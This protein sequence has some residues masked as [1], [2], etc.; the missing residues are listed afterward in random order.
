MCGIAGFLKKNVSKHISDLKSMANVL[1]HRGPDGEGMWISSDDTIGMIHTRLSIIDLTPAGDQPMISPSKR[2]TM[3]FNGEVYNHQEIKCELEKISR[4]N[5]RGTSDTEV[6]LVAIDAW[7]LEKALSKVRGMLSIALWDDCKKNIYLASDRMGEKPLYYGWVGDSFVFGSELKSLKSISGL[8][9]EIDRSSLS[10]YMRYKSIPAPH[11]IYKDIYKITPG[12]IIKTNLESQK[13]SKSLYWSID[14][15]AKSGCENRFKGSSEQAVLKLED[16]LME[17]IDLQM[18]ADV[19]LGSFLSGGVDSSVVS[20]LMQSNSYEKINTFSIGFKDKRFNEAEYARA[21]SKSIGSSHHDMY[22]TSYD[23]MN[24]IPSLPSI[25][26][27]PFS[28]SS[29]IPTFLV[30]KIAKEKVSVV[31][32]GDG[33]DELFGGYNRYTLSSKLWGNIS[34]IPLPIRGLMSSG[35]KSISPK[36]WDRLLSFLARSKYNNFGEKFHKG[37]N[38]LNCNDMDELYVNLISQVGNP[39]SWVLNSNSNEC[40]D[41]STGKKKRFFDLSPIERMMANDLAGYLSADILTKVD[42]A[43]MAVSLEARTPF[44]DSKVVEFALSL[45]LN[46]KIRNGVGKWVLREVLYKHVPRGL[47]E[48]PKMGFEMPLNEWLRGPLREWSESL[49]NYNR[50]RDEGYFDADIVRQKWQEHISGQYNWQEQLWSVLMFQS[51][52]EGEK[53]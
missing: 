40:L 23:A 49:L 14:D 4:H 35:I 53:K 27:E 30:S 31:L 24:I 26:D 42:R 2:Y 45:P 9:F 51:W 32:T 50:L 25:Y 19:P 18:Q 39:E 8:I 46:Y 20:A 16:V 41:V 7:G 37:A 38:S 6:L 15:M 13:I 33:A 48:R 52:L 28:D 22:V 3:A 47:I 34:K 36:N 10:L 29:Q 11:S 5:W 43:S 12:S 21:V 44:L 17:S 1:S